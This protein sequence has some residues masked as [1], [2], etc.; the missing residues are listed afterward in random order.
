MGVRYDNVSL[1]FDFIGGGLSTSG[2]LVD[3]TVV[4]LAGKVQE[5]SFHPVYGQFGVLA[6][7]ECLPEVVHFIVEKLRFVA[8]C[9]GF[10]GES[11]NYI[12]FC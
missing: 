5:P 11:I 6:A 3:G 9:F 10:L 2:V 12:I 4:S 1:V 8:Y 7:S